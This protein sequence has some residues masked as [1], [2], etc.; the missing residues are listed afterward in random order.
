MHIAGGELPRI[1]LL[2]PSMNF[3]RQPRLESSSG[4]RPHRTGAQPSPAPPRSSQGLLAAPA[5]PRS[6]SVKGRHNATATIAAA[7]ETEQGQASEAV[8]NLARKNPP[9]TLQYIVGYCRICVEKHD[10]RCRVCSEVGAPRSTKNRIIDGKRVRALRERAFYSR[11]ELARMA[12]LDRSTVGRIEE[13]ETVVHP[14]TVRRLAKA[15][16]VD[17]SSLVSEGRS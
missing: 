5:G 15:L 16:S 10:R 11:S 4:P 14:R 7:P 1:L 8:A 17:P 3:R 12:G 9:M 2:R 6:Q 13:G